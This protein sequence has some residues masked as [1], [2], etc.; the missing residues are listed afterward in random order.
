MTGYLTV[1]HSSATDEWSTP[2][3]VV[4]QAAAEFGPFDLDPAATPDNAKAP[5][6]FTRDD[7]G[8]ARRWKGRVWLNPPY[9][10]TVGD[11][12]DKARAEVDA[13][14]AEIVVCLVPARVDAR[15]WQRNVIHARPAPLVRFW[16]RRLQYVPGRDAPFAS[17][18]VV[19][20]QLP[21][22][23]G[24][25]ARR[26]AQCDDWWFPPRSDA[27]TCSD[28]CRQALSRKARVIRDTG[29]AP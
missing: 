21:G 25:E 24:T 22:R 14:R 13:G 26:C 7:D 19:F 29:G 17:A 10:R 15:W 28:R 12:M 8:L 1:G 3:W 4:D 11:W 18:T 27:K 9:G 2:Q 5:V 6:F 23:H 16:P 20:G